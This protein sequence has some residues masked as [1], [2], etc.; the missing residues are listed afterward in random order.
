[1]SKKDH[2]TANL[3][4]FSQIGGAVL[5]ALPKAIDGIDSKQLI[6]ALNKTGEGLET[7][8][9]QLFNNMIADASSSLTT[10]L[11]KFLDTI[12]IPEMTEPFVV[13]NHFV[14]NTSDDAEVKISYIGDDVKELFFGKT[15]KPLA[16]T[17]IRRY[18]LLKS[19]VDGPI[20]AK[21]GGEQKAEITL[22]Q[23]YFLMKNQGK[24]EQGVL[25]TNGCTNIFYVR[26]INNMLRAV[27]VY[28]HGGGWLVYA[29]SVEYPIRWR[30]GR[31]VFT[32]NS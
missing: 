29:N 21:L 11:L 28:W 14:V 30:A 2:G 17:I 7:G 31:Q 12:I 1:M 22:S 13:K 6:A 5:K 9:A 27:H 10:K 4:Q 23:I 32:S 19:S 3:G 25:L 18:E 26:D 16:Q 20:I 8:L 24:G 15:E